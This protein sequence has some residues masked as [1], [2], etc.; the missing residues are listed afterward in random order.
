MQVMNRRPYYNR[1]GIKIEYKLNTGGIPVHSEVEI[2]AVNITEAP[3]PPALGEDHDGSLIR[4]GALGSD[5]KQASY[6]L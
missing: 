4:A 3:V 1:R 2:D 5:A 6:L